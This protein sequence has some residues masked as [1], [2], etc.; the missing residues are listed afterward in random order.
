MGDR[1]G[2]VT[3]TKSSSSSDTVLIFSLTAIT[4][5]CPTMCL[6]GGF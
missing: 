3:S 5:S 1:N 4:P 6:A 2:W